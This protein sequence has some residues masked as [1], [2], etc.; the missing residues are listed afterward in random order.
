MNQFVKKYRHKIIDL[1]SNKGKE[2]IQV[3]YDDIITDRK[4]KEQS[5]INDKSL[6]KSNRFG[7]LEKYNG[8][9]EFVSNSEK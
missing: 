2:M 9:L 5:T 7:S 1:N 8:H 6:D 3:H 4:K